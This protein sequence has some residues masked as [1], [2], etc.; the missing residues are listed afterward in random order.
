MR[1]A[2]LIGDFDEFS[3]KYKNL[4]N[5]YCKQFPNLKIDVDK[6]IAVYKVNSVYIINDD[7]FLINIK[8]T[9]KLYNQFQKLNVSIFLFLS[10]SQTFAT[11]LKTL[12]IVTDTVVY[13]HNALKSS[14]SKNV[15]VEGA[16]GALLDIDFG[17]S[18]SIN[19]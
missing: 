3:A 18:S 6:E 14:P 9:N 12:G 5:T 8:K 19:P 11:K 15:L 17:I 1:V 10:I 4:V 16:N 2:D 7:T 13:M